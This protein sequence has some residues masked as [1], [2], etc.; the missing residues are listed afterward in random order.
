MAK[1]QIVTLQINNLA[2]S[3]KKY[4]SLNYSIEILPTFTKIHFEKLNRLNLYRCDIVKIEALSWM[5]FPNIKSINL[6]YNFI[7]SYN[8]LA[9][10]QFQINDLYGF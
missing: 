9:K 2:N 8:S 7:N 4:L 3:S 10:C 6:T 5:N 1:T